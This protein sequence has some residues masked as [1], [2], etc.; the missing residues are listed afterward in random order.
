MKQ[1][2]KTDAE[3]VM[4]KLYQIK[5]WLIEGKS[6]AM[7]CKEPELSEQIVQASAIPIP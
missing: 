4:L 3:Q 6:L 1:G 7:T 2:E 5:I